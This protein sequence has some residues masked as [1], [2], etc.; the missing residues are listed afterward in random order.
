MLLYIFKNESSGSRQEL[1][2]Q[3][4]GNPKVV[5]SSDIY[6]KLRT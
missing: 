1:A 2:Q 5:K 4:S 3:S 6:H